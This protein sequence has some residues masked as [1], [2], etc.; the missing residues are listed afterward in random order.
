M[1]FTAASGGEPETYT[2]WDIQGNQYVFLGFDTNAGVAKGQIWKTIDP[3][4][5]T[6][7]VGDSTTASTAISNGFDGSGRMLK[8]YDSADRRYTYSYTTFT[9]AGTRLTEVKAETKSGGTWASPTGLATVADVT[10]G[11]YE[12]DGD[13]YGDAGDLKLIKVTTPLTDSGIEIVTKTYIR[14]WQGTFNSSTN[15]GHPHDIQYVY[16]SEGLRQFDWAGDSTFDEDFLTASENDLKPYASAYYEYDSRYRITKS[17]W[18]GFG[19]RAPRARQIG[20]A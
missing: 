9:N 10:Y 1:N 16:G 4:G 8:A 2:L 18:V 17:W 15:P 5:N 19:S 20:H 12:N 14:Y 13:S 7:Y 3:A 11:Y 6:A